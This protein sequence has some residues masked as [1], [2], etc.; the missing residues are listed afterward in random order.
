MTEL[1]KLLREEAEHAEQHADAPADSGTTVSKPGHARSSVY[2]VRLNSDELAA[3][4]ALAEETGI[5][6]S[7]LVRSWILER[8]R[9]GG[10]IR[11]ELR[12][13]IH[14][15]VREAVQD[16]LKTAS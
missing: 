14:D 6:S 12:Q 15:E 1:D 13:L 10:G 5:P 8:I 9:P 4:Q 2:S 7:A 11:G 16:A 3:L